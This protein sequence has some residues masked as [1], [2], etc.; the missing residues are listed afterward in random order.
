MQHFRFFHLFLVHSCPHYPLCNDIIWT[1]DVPSLSHEVRNAPPPPLFNV[2]PCPGFPLNLT[3]SPA[4]DKYLLHSIL[5]L[6]ASELNASDSTVVSAALG[7]R[8]EAVRA[9][10][11]RLAARGG[12]R[13]PPW[14]TPRGTRSYGGVLRAHLPER[15]YLEDGMAEHMAFVRGAV[16]VALQ[17]AGAALE[18]LRLLCEVSGLRVK[19]LEMTW[20]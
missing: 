8:L 4:Q 10:R 16:L 9:I 14:N 5:G 19:Y 12:D 17:M 3:I 13:L 2:S 11:Q 1:R 7:H 15:L 18:G 6:A 20:I